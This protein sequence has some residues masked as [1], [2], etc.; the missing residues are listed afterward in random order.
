VDTTATGNGISF[1]TADTVTGIV[2]PLANTEYETTNT[3]TVNNNILLDGTLAGGPIPVTANVAPNSF[4][5]QNNAVLALSSGVLLN[6]SSGGILV[7]AGSTSSITGG[8]VNQTSTFSPL[9][10]WTLGDLTISST[11]NGGVGPS[12]TVA[13]LFNG[14]GNVSLV[15]AGAGTL[16]LSPGASYIYGNNSAN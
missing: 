9:D 14:N 15:K 5:F 8:V 6:N 16:T 1:A 2:R 4:T 3:V 13:G 7:R 10:I 11:L 12:F